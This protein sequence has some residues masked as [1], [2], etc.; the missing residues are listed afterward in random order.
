MGKARN[1][2]R[3]KIRLVWLDS[4]GILSTKQLAEQTGIKP[5]Q[6]RKWKSM[7]QWQDQLD[8]QKA[9]KH[10]GGQPKNTNAIGA[11]APP[12]NLNA[13]THGAYATTRL[14]HLP[15]EQLAY[16]ES[17]TLNTQDH[18]L[19]EMKLLMA[20]E[21]DLQNKITTLHQANQDTLYIDRV[22]EM[23][24]PDEAQSD[25]DSPLPSAE[26]EYKVNMKTIMKASAFERIMKIEAELNKVHGRII[27]LID[28]IKGYEL[29][30]RRQQ[31]EECKYNLA[32]QRLLGV[33]DDANG[34]SDPYDDVDFVNN[35]DDL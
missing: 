23:S 15:P 32:R 30:C 27:K 29:E 13:Q 9:M 25:D 34:V 10:R 6:I 11:G 1:P 26:I 18:M 14:S 3:D 35:M 2:M 22:V 19:L 7:D 24:I 33:Y 12:C 5:A 4:G 16:I 20:K 21:V 17:I 28:S 31:L 8:K